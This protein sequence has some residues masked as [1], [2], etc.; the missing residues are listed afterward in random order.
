MNP[1]ILLLIL[2]SIF[3][4]NCSNPAPSSNNMILDEVKY[5]NKFPQ[6]FTLQNREDPNIDIIGIKGF[7]IY[8]SLVILTTGNKNGFWSFISL[9]DYNYYGN[10]LTIGQGPFEFLFPLFAGKAILYKEKNQLHASM[11]DM[12]KG[13][14]YKMNIDESIRT[15]KLHLVKEAAINPASSAF[16]RIDSAKFFCKE[17]SIDNGVI[18]QLRY[19]L[20]DNTKVVPDVL[21]KLNQAAI[22]VNEDL[23]ILTTITK[24]STKHNL[25]VEA[26][27]YLNY[28]NMYSLDGSFGKTICVGNR[29]DDIDKIQDKGEWDRIQTYEDLRIFPDFWGVVLIDEDR[30]TYQIGREKLPSVF[31]FNWRG[32]P[33][34]ELKLKHFITSFDIDF[35]HG[36]LYTLDLHSDEFYRYDIKDIL[37]KLK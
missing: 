27:V 10:F 12:Q 8:D 36:H 33:L 5:V 25:I 35:A 26:P 7:A 20:D 16:V 13:E 19:I 28:I 18:Q 29:L 3:L 37:A 22:R 4:I 9:P 17:L 11:Y 2:S 21:Q 32:E 30:K 23:N 15:K 31:L 1:K 14:I 34:A 24:F 6:T